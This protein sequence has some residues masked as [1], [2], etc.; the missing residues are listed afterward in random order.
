MP[1]YNCNQRTYP[2]YGGGYGGGYAPRFGYGGG[3]YPAY[4]GGYP[5]YPQLSYPS[6]AGYLSNSINVFSTIKTLD[7]S[8]VSTGDVAALNN[9]D[10]LKFKS[11]HPGLVIKGDQ[12]TKTIS[13]DISPQVTVSTANITLKHQNK[14]LLYSEEAITAGVLD[15]DDALNGQHLTIVNKNSATLV[16]AVEGTSNVSGATASNG[17]PI[18]QARTFVYYKNASGVKLWYPTSPLV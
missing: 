3:G 4:G 17:I 7:K 10:T 16:F 15:T 12:A 8:D 11:L 1:Y 5:A 6:T 9:Y 18:K 13:F 14:D 2:S